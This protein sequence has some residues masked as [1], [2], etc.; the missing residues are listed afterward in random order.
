MTLCVFPPF[1]YSCSYKNLPARNPHLKV[2]GFGR[3]EPHVA[4]AQG[5]HAI[6]QFEFLQNR[7]GVKTPN[8]ALF[9][10]PPRL[11]FGVELK[12]L[13]KPC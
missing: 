2:I 11:H 3:A 12:D 1:Y 5:Q 6:G 10:I 8:Q 13:Y 4:G 9:G 7:L